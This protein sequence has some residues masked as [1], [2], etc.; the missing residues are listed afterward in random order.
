[1]G[2]DTSLNGMNAGQPYVLRIAYMGNAAHLDECLLGLQ[3]HEVCGGRIAVER[4]V[5]EG[6]YSSSCGC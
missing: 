4:H 6:C 1:M 5:K 2:V 3:T